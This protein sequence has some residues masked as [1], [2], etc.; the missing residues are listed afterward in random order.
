MRGKPTFRLALAGVLLSGA[1]LGQKTTQLTG[2]ITDQSA[3]V[4]PGANLTVIN[5]DTGIKRATESNEL[6]YY[7]VPLLQPGHYRVTV[8]KE[9]FR[10]LTRSG[11]TLEVE[12]TA[13][14]DFVLELG[15]V[16]ESVQ[17][18]ADVSRVDTVSS[19]LKEVVDA[20]R[21]RELPL[22]GRDANQLIFLLPGVYTTNDT[23]GLQQGG[24]ARGI[25]NPGV[26][27]N[28]ARSNMVNYT[29]DGGISHTTPTRT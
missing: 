25:V 9:G 26:S 16:T 2:R 23:S 15:A 21:I 5:E 10:P 1:L 19:V 4:I 14:V 24:S 17:V 20:R 28:G 8:Q 7:T 12:Q 22:N 11:I 3:A 29:L 27:S 6:G 13:R 18:T